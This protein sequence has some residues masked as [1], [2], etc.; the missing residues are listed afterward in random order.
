MLEKIFE[1]HPEVYKYSQLAYSKPSFLFLRWFSN[2]ILWRNPARRSWVTSFFSDSIKDLIDS[3]E[4]NINL[5][6]LDDENLS[7]DYSWHHWK[8][9]IAKYSIFPK[10]LHRDQTPKTDKLIILGSPLGPKSQADLLEKKINEMEKV[11]GIVEKLEGHY[12]FSCWKNASVC[13][14]CC[15]FWEPVHILIIQ[16]SWNNMTKQSV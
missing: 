11:I 9:T 14:G 6:Y 15:T 12:G 5:W 3:L 13:Q 2:Q 10:N 1:I 4:S 7:D 16:L 8:T